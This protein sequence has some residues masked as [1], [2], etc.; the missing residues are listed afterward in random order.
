MVQGVANFHKN[1]CFIPC[2]LLSRFGQR[3]N[4]M[5]KCMWQLTPGKI[6]ASA[7]I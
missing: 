2:R 7:K 3:W 1:Y 5:W 6:F 4:F